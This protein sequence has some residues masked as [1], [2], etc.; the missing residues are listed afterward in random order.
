MNC[1]ARC[2]ESD[3][4]LAA[5]GDFLD[6]LSQLGW[7]YDEIR[8]VASAVIGLLGNQQ[9]AFDRSIDAV[10]MADRWASN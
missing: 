9:A 8:D 7:E 4:P 2:A 6:E 10:T 1:F 3:A 5:V